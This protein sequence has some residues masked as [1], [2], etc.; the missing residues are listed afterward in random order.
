MMDAETWLNGEEAQALGLADTVLGK[1]EL[2]NSLDSISKQKIFTGFT[3]ANLDRIPVDLRSLFDT[4]S[5]TTTQATP[6]QAPTNE[7]TAEQIA[8]LI[9]EGLTNHAKENPGLTLEVVKTELGNHL[10]DGLKPINEALTKVAAL[11]EEVTKLNT[12]LADL[13]LR[14]EKAENVIKSGVLS[15]AGGTAPGNNLGGG[16]ENGTTTAPKNRAELE[17]AMKGKTMNERVTML[18]EF[19]ARK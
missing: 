19:K 12:T 11:P 6:P 7:M 17:E 10:T 14:L 15:T 9:K 4:P 5:Q 2:T 16:E 13:T 1:V 3:P 8:A 18:N